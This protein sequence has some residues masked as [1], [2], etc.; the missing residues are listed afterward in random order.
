MNENYCL[1]RIRDQLKDL[2]ASHKPPDPKPLGISPWVAMSLVQKAI[3]RGHEGLALQAAATLLR[4]APERLW[5]RLGAIAHEDIGLGDLA[6]AGLVT[7]ALAGKTV[8][9]QLGGEWRVASFLVAR[10][11]KAR[12]CR[13]TDDLLFA[14]ENHPAFMTA[15]MELGHHTRQELLGI[16]TGTAPLIER[17]IALRFLMGTSQRTSK[18]LLPRRGEPHAVFEALFN[19]GVPPCIVA[20]AREAYRKSG[21]PLAPLVALNSQE[22]G[23]DTA[24]T[25]DDILPPETM[26]GETPCWALDWF[27]REGRATLSRFLDTDAK[28]AQ[29]IV[30]HVIPAKRAEMLANLVFFIEG[31]CLNRRLR[32]PVGDELRRKA[33]FEC[34]ACPDATEPLVL[35]LADLPLMNALRQRA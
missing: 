5:S 11:A 14:T 12:K 10:M 27:S 20:V 34:L 32:W 28:T 1:A 23:W 15:R 9:A 2:M 6:T 16:V 35:M 22:E 26:I 31:S 17:A 25:S 24:T 29:W 4:D 8:R 3:R 18:Q 33:A 21:E 13:A 19:A 30:T 7:A